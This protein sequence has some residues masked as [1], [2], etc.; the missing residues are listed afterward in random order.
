MTGSWAARQRRHRR[1]GR[2]RHETSSGDRMDRSM[3]LHNII[4][5]REGVER[6]L[7]CR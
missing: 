4:S 2:V 3:R 7:G 5:T 6:S 1:P